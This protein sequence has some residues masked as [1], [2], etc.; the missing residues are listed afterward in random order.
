MGDRAYRIMNWGLR[1]AFPVA[2]RLS[3]DGLANVPASGPVIVAI[4]H[5]SF[6]DAMLVG[7]YVPRPVVMMSKIENFSIP[8]G[9]WIVKM[10]GAFPIRRGAVDRESIKIA[11]EVLH[12]GRVLLMAPEGTRSPDGQLQPG[13]DGVAMLAART[14]AAVVPFAVAG[15]KPVWTNLK[16]LHRTRVA[17]HV[18]EPL[19]L[20]D[21][22]EKPSRPQLAQLTDRVM[23]RLAALLPAE[24]RG[25]Y[26]E[27]VPA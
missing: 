6:V 3:I 8:I 17:V 9:G 2:L 20:T 19:M 18:G 14:G 25:A 26:R 4:N 12:A 5:S 16:R 22:G 24:Q 13:H 27:R 7:A 21:F 11:L 15:S 1:R 23:L 10:Y